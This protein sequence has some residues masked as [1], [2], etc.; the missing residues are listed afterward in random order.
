MEAS[1]YGAVGRSVHG[2]VVTEC[3]EEADLAQTLYQDMEG[4]TVRVIIVK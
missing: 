4:I 2:H 1:R 3:S